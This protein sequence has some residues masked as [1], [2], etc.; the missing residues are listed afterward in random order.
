MSVAEIID[1]KKV[2]AEIRQEVKQDVDELKARGITPG[3]AVVLVGDNPASA[4]YVRMKVK[5]CEEVGIYSRVIRL[6]QE[7][8]Q[9]E[10]E[11]VVDDLN[12]DEAIHGMLVQLPLPPQ[13]EEKPIIWR[14]APEKDVDGFHPMN[15]GRMMIGDPD[16]FRPA[17][18]AGVIELLMRS[19]HNPEGKRVT[20]VGRSN[21]VGRPL[22]VLLSQ[23]MR[24]GNATV[25]LA[26]SR[27][28]ELPAVLREADIL[29]AAIGVAEFVKG[30]SVKPGA[31][32]IDVGVN[33]VDDPSSEKGYRLVGDVA[34]DE[35]SRIAGAITPVPGGVGPM[36][37]AMLLTN[38]VTATRRISG[39]S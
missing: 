7:T 1:G 13:I 23:K 16:A 4:V 27:T 33:R 8:S 26:H 32:V 36:T 24:G 37:I 14:I 31:V 5:A 17:T 20:I 19:G 10:L 22:A 28:P 6:P 35:V 9:S 3:L 2:A 30:D 38:C 39:I 34:F 25:T 15:V 18:P 12:E 29:V 21:I 11:S